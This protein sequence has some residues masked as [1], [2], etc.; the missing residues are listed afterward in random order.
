MW[1]NQ[2]VIDANLVENFFIF[3]QASLFGFDR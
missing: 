2:P 3:V 1:M